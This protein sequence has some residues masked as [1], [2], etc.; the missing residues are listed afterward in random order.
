MLL[1][2]SAELI[3]LVLD[4]IDTQQSLCALSVT[5]KLLHDE[6]IKNRLISFNIKHCRGWG[7]RFAAAKG[8]IALVKRFLHDPNVDIHATRGDCGMVAQRLGVGPNS[9]EAQKG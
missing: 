7:L 4:M 2:L 9:A 3:D 8:D 6:F 5:N 1:T